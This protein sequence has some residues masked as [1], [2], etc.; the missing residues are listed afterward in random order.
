[1]CSLQLPAPIR[2]PFGKLRAV[3]RRLAIWRRV[4]LNLSGATPEDQ[5]ILSDA[6]RRSPRTVWNDL[7]QWQFPMVEQDCTVVALGGGLFH[8]RARTDDLF[9]ALPN[10]EPAV[11]QAVR[12]RL[13]PGDV[14]VDAG[15]NIGYY[16]ILASKLV[17]PTGSVISVE[18][19]PDTAAI[20]R[21]HV[22]LNSLDN[23]R[24]VEAALSDVAGETLTASAPPGK[25]GQASLGVGGSCA[26][27]S[28]ST[29]T[30][31]DVLRDVP[32]VALMKLDVEGVE[33]RVLKGAGDSLTRIDAII[34]ES[35]GQ[36]TDATDYLC[37]NGFRVE[38]LD[39]RNKLAVNG[40]E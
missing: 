1:M 38:A 39:D 40:Q 19:L 21:R 5:R 32:R 2:R 11:E 30:L 17:E 18:M 13:K 14:F 8:V 22:T 36:D 33:L 35:W 26:S 15:A 24:V 29:T 12:K 27:V 28:V 6:I 10:Q 4:N 23:V 9:H 20:L 3:A 16:T 37:A 34:F 31:N 7:D 25:F